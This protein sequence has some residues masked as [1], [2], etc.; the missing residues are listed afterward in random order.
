MEFE[1]TPVDSN[2]ELFDNLLYD[3]FTRPV[4]V[5]VNIDCPEFATYSSGILSSPECSGQKKGD[6]TLLL[7]GYGT[8]N[9][10]DYWIARNRYE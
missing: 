1:Y 6:H 9:G 3:V 8:E 10:V 5:D 2:E 7:V 4:V